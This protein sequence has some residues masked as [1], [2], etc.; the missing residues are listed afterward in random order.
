M[1]EVSITNKCVKFAKG[2]FEN[3]P[4]D[5]REVKMYMVPGDATIYIVEVDDIPRDYTKYQ[6]K[7]GT[8]FIMTNDLEK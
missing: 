3:L 5:A 7:N 6:F 8:S 1:A 2:K 4:H